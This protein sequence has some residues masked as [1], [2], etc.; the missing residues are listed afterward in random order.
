[1][2]GWCKRRGPRSAAGRPESILVQERV[3]QDDELAHDGGQG[4]F[5]RLSACSQVVVPAG[6]IRVVPDGSQ[7]RAAMKSARRARERLPRMKLCPFHFPDSRVTGAR[8][9]R[10][11]AVLVSS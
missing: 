11:A 3:G 2:T 4:D 9:A 10:L 7:G 5:R 6:Q 8:P 1:M